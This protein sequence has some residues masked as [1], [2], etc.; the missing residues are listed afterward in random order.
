MAAIDEWA[1]SIPIE[2]LKAR[3][4]DIENERALIRLILH[5]RGEEGYEPPMSARPH[6]RPGS[7]REFVRDFLAKGPKSRQ[8]IAAAFPGS[9]TTIDTTIQRMANEYGEIER[10]GHGIYQLKT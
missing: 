5:Q 7:S 8:Q 2:D 1:A 3:L 4:R 6:T 10:V 9:L